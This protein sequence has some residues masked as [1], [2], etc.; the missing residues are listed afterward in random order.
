MRHFIENRWVLHAGNGA[1]EWEISGVTIE[2]GESRASPPG[3]RHC[4]VAG[5]IILLYHDIYIISTYCLV[6]MVRDQFNNRKIII[7]WTLSADDIAAVNV[8]AVLNF[9]FFINFTPPPTAARKMSFNYF[10]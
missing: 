7:A 1:V 8:Y 5:G 9:F 3:N 10:I 4:S 2:A 6:L